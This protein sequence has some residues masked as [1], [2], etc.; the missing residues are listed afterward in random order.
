MKL[1]LLMTALAV[2]IAVPAMAE[3]DG[4]KSASDRNANDQFTRADTNSDGMVSQ[5][6]FQEAKISGP[7]WFGANG[8]DANGDGVI[9]RS[10]FTTAQ[11]RGNDRDLNSVAP[12]S[13]RDRAPNPTYNQ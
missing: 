4:T 7:S 8:A 11:A 1:K 2:T 5:T 12:S 3:G 9:S 13:G 10:E 6:E